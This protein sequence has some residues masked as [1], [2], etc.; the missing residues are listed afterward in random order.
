[1]KR[2]QNQPKTAMKLFTPE[3]SW[4]LENIGLILQEQETSILINL[5][6]SPCKKELIDKAMKYIEEF[7]TSYMTIRTKKVFSK[8]FICYS[9]ANTLLA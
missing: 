2:N 5:S 8:V 9:Q 3:T 7:N 4:D 1:M 6:K